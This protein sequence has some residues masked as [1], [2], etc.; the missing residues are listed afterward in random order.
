MANTT[1]TD[2]TNGQIAMVSE[3][4]YTYQH[5]T[6]CTGIFT[7]MPLPSGEK[8]KFI[9]KYGN[10]T[11]SDLTD[12]VD[13]VDAQQLTITGT[14]HTTDEAGCKVIITKKLRHQMKDDVYRSTGK[15]IGNAIRKKIDDDGLALFSS[16]DSG[17]G[18]TYY[19]LL[20]RA[21][22]KP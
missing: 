1:A 17:L 12:G 15:V 14:T 6:V 8:S 13:M 18:G 16:I 20:P 10:V 22:A 2:L 9:P 4:R 7:R 11:A 3:A 19:G 21:F 5:N